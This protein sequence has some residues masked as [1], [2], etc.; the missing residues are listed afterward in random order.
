MIHRSILRGL[1]WAGLVSTFVGCGMADEMGHKMDESNNNVQETLEATRLLKLSGAINDMLSEQSS[2]ELVPIPTGVLAG[3]KVFAENARSRELIE[4]TAKGLA[5]IDSVQ[6]LPKFDDKGNE[7]APTIDEQNKE[8]RNKFQ[9]LQAL[10]AIAGYLPQGKVVQLIDDELRGAYRKTL[11]KVLMMRAEFISTTRVNMS[12]L[13]QGVTLAAEAR[14]ASEL[15]DTVD[16]VLSLPFATE[17]GLTTMGLTGPGTVNMNFDH[18]LD[19]KNA[20]PAKQQKAVDTFKLMVEPWETLALA[21]QSLPPSAPHS[22][23][24]NPTED[25][26]AQEQEKKSLVQVLQHCQDRVNYWKTQVP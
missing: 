9:Y 8:F 5:R 20:D 26:I 19:V 16:Y 14:E 2:N 21:I 1:L 3:A 18:S 6:P 10:R 15:M 4:F 22:D 17:I 7:V 25:K 23:S 12:W 24:G 11:M 13:S